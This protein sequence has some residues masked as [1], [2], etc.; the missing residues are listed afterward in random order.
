[1]TNTTNQIVKKEAYQSAL[2]KQTD[3][4]TN[5]IIQTFANISLE[6]D[7]YQKVCL[8]NAIAKINELLTANGLAFGDAKIN[9]SNLTTV[10]SQ[11]AMFRLNAAASPRECYF[12]LRNDKNSDKKIIEFG[13][14]GNGNDSILRDYGVNVK[15][16]MP[17]IVI[18]EGD[19]FQYP[20]FDGEKMQPFTW[21]PKSFTAK[22]IAVAYVIT[23]KDGTKEYLISERESVASNLKAHIS[24][25]LLGVYDYALKNRITDKISN[26]TLDEMLSDE[27]LIN[28]VRTTD[29]NGKS[30]LIT[31]ISPA[32]KSSQSR[33][34]MII[35]KMKNNC[36]KK[37]PKD[38]KNSY[39]ALEYEQT[40]E[41][42]PKR[43]YIDAETQFDT[44]QEVEKETEQNAA[45]KEMPEPQVE[46]QKEPEQKSMEDI[47]NKALEED[48]K[49][50]S[51]ESLFPDL[52]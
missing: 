44:A 23:K 50:P 37:Y 48:P 27:E 32:W 9:Q 47:F 25:N 5:M 19:E 15:D 4:Y 17:P 52:E 36:T 39:V 8:A 10:L 20:Y 42:M 21:K 14:E 6:L 31:L 7:T 30:K 28:G 12:Q 18:R 49:E 2:S 22:P 34:E 40:A 45:K 29:S 1:M 46:E 41:D 11:I 43:D 35:R 51:Q 26:M 38:F 33:E 13:I 3:T 16:V 24:N